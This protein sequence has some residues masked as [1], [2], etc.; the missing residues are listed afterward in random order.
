[1]LVDVKSQIKL[2]EKK[3]NHSTGYKNAL[4]CTELNYSCLIFFKMDT[5]QNICKDKKQT[6]L[7]FFNISIS[8]RTES[9]QQHVL[10]E[11]DKPVEVCLYQLKY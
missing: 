8:C 4:K 5:N 11:A 10:W 9:L 1:M 6:H 7:V 2:Y 3:L